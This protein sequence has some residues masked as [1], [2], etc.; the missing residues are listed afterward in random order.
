MI[1]R[2]HQKKSILRLM[3]SVIGLAGAL[4]LPSCGII[5]APETLELTESE[6]ADFQAVTAEAQN[7]ST[8]KLDLSSDL[9]Y[10]FLIRQLEL[11]GQT[12]DNA[13]DADRHN[14]HPFDRNG[15]IHLDVPTM[16]ISDSIRV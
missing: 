3:I 9:H 1:E 12:E 8:L 11:A 7:G 4:G 14:R 2:V 13:P 10:R 15:D 16:K 6:L 5:P